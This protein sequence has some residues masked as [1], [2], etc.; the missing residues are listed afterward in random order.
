V[1]NEPILC[2]KRYQLK[3]TNNSSF[4]KRQKEVA[5]IIPKSNQFKNTKIQ[6]KITQPQ[7]HFNQ[8]KYRQLKQPL[9]DSR[10][11]KK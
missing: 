9:F 6:T 5:S 2:N 1:Y 7:Y 11:R 10:F 3:R 4:N 8:N